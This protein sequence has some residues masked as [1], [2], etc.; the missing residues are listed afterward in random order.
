M[1]V[2]NCNVFPKQRLMTASIFAGLLLADTVL[3]QGGAEKVRLPE[4]VVTPTRSQREM[5]DIPFMC[6]SIK[7]AEICLGKASRTTPEAL[8]ELPS[9]MIQK[10]AHGQ[11]SP[12]LRGFTGFRT[13]FLVDGIRLNNSVFRDGPN[14]YWNTV[15]P[16]SISRLEVLRGPASVLFGSDAIG[17]AVNAISRAGRD[18]RSGRILPSRLYYRFSTAER[19]HILRGDANTRLGKAGAFHVGLTLK[20]FGDLRSGAGRQPKTGYDEGD[21][22]LRADFDL[23]SGWNITIGHQTVVQND[24]WRTHKTIFA[25]SYHGTTVGNE[26]KRVLDQRRNFTYVRL[27]AD[28]FGGPVD[29]LEFV[30]SHH[31]QEEDRFRVKSNYSSDRQGV[32]VDTLGLSMQALKHAWGEWTCGVEYYHDSVDSYSHKYSSGGQLKS[33]GIQG[34]VGDDSTYDTLGLY[35]QNTVD[36]ERLQVI[37]GARYN[38]C[39]ADVGHFQDP[40]SGT[41]DSLHE[42]WDA[43]VGSLRLMYRLLPQDRVNVFAGV[44]QGF[45]APNLSDL[46]RFDTARTDEIETPSPGVDPEHYL[47]CEA[48]IK[49]EA[50]AAAFQLA[51]FHTLIR[52]MIIRVPTGRIIDGSKE[53]TKKNAGDGFVHGVELE[54]RWT[55]SSSW[56]VWG[57]LTWMEGEVDSFPTSDP[58]K[59]RE[60]M[61]RIMPSTV[62]LTTRY[63]PSNRWWVEASVTAA[64]KQDRLST[65]DKADTQRIPPGGTPGYAVVSLRSGCKLSSHLTLTAVLDNVT[66]RNYRIHGSGVNEPGRNFILVAEY[67][68]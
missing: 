26:R 33:C 44:S 29:Q 52:D 31:R 40:V 23:S 27:L 16:F 20:R 12:F 11:G 25:R 19:S 67:K 57:N 22:D 9:V 15:D 13:L 51:Y 59:K 10:T 42:D 37:S 17:G 39:E 4:I 49:A 48:G 54:T 66:D 56:R 6:D 35:I 5:A 8:R 36:S 18:S 24:S 2:S 63:Q 53:V 55:I 46:T 41:S 68:F 58:I 61:S 38:R 45:R 62:N 14:Q 47:A 1:W 43:V 30:L 34:P 3:A 32:D 64:D 50:G 7:G 21:V 28:D 65:R 60:P